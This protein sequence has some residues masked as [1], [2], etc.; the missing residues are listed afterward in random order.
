VWFVEACMG[1][2]GQAEVW[3]GRVW[4]GKGFHPLANRRIVTVGMNWRF[5]WPGP[6]VP[7]YGGSMWG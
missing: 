4:L 5:G 2:A 7:G 1:L 6:G 3:R